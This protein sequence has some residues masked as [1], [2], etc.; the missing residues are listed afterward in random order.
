MDYTDRLRRLALNDAT[1]AQAVGGGPDVEPHFLDAKSVALVRLGALIA[2]GGAVPSYAELAD[3][4]VDAGASAAEIVDVL[5][6][7]IRVVGFPRVVAEAP[8]LALALGYDTEEAF[9]RRS[10]L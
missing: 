4:A 3:A 5:F 8:K 10:G 9:E 6:S 7:A 1:F 2:E